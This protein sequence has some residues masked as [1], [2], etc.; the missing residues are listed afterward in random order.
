MSE[1]VWKHRF[2]RERIARK[3]A[4]R[5]LEEKSL[6]LHQSN[7]SLRRLASELDALIKSRTSELTLSLRD[8]EQQKRELSTLNDALTQ[9]RGVA[10]TASRLKGEFLANMSHEI[11]T[12]M[13]GIIGMV[14]LTLET[15]LNREQ[16]EYLNLAKSSAEHL[17]TVI[18]D[19]LDFSKIEAGKLDIQDTEF[20][21]INLIGETLKSM[22]PR[23]MLK[24]LELTYDLGIETPRFARG[25]PARLRQIFINLLGNAIKFTE[26]GEVG[27]AVTGCGSIGAVGEPVCLEFTVHDTGTGIPPEKQADIFSAFTQVEGQ[28]IRRY[29]GTGLG[30]TISRQL[31]EMM[32]GAIRVESEVGQGSRFIFQ[33]YLRLAPETEDVQHGEASLRDVRVLAVDDID[34]NLRVL[35]LMLGSL[36]MRHDEARN[37]ASAVDMA[38]RALACGDPYRLILL[39]ARMPGMDGFA[40]AERI[41]ADARHAGTALLMLTSAGLR[42]DAARCQSLGLDVYLTKPVTLSELRESMEA[43]LGRSER[44]GDLVT[45]HTLRE[46]RPR[47][48]VLLAE[49]NLVN[50]MLAVK[51]LKKREYEVT[52]VENGRLAMDAWRAGCFDFILMDMMMPEMDGL[53]ATRRIRAEERGHGEHIPII[54]MTANAMTGDRE[55]CLDSGMDG[56]LSKPVKPEVL[57]Q[58]IDRVMSGKPADT[59]VEARPTGAPEAGEPV[60]DRADALSRIADDEDL[61]T[62]LIDM[63]LDDVPRYL[64]D[65]DAALAASDWRKLGHAAH[66]LKG[67]L[68][69]FSARR[70]EHL[71]RDL[72]QAAKSGLASD[73]ANLVPKLHQE[74][75][76]FLKA[77]G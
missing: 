7:Q 52:V 74:V 47:Y 22:A 11:R 15:D 17:L 41:R 32:G 13:N 72:E 21:L 10:E 18:N 51:L 35:S 37:G 71:A 5:I 66:T 29:G 25:D 19:I 55:R 62:S 65:V 30:L 49:D 31:V 26:K 63:F 64:S 48:N 44:G 53:E 28:E 46:D 60:F 75:M 70:G 69:T 76:A 73:C 50:Q 36:H 4:E 23:A 1:D 54:A 24:D 61:L 27:L 38:D 39:D 33:I 68:A 77:V 59:S 34:T 40:V 3:E 8:S 16:R 57:Y 42:G 14:D 45:R 67:V 56:Y 6:D 2:E 12:P 9:A 58:E 43:I 20:D